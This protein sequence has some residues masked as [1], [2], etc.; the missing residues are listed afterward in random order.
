MGGSLGYEGKTVSVQQRARSHALSMH[1]P[2]RARFALRGQFRTFE[3]L[4]ALNDDV[5]AGMS[6]ADFVVLA[7]DREV[8][9]AVYVVAGER[10][11]RITADVAGAGVLELVVKTSRW[12]W[13]HAVW[14]DPRIERQASREAAGPLVDCLGRAEL[15]APAPS[16]STERCIATVVSPGFEGLLDDMLGSLAA[17]GD[18]Q[19]AT[20]VVVALNPNAACTTVARKYGAAIIRARA[21]APVTAASKAVL[22]SIA[23]VDSQFSLSGRGHASADSLSPLF[24]ALARFRKARFWPSVR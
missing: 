24:A 17:N 8:A 22:Y 2:A 18:C 10:P 7:D 11:R 16:I 19:G 15:T 21:L 1:P 4:V 5:P 14:V 20:L 3:A 12:E 6:H 23:L 9:S 13:S